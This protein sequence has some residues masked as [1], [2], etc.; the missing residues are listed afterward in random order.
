[1]LSGHGTISTIAASAHRIGS[2]VDGSSRYTPLAII[3]TVSSLNI[4]GMEQVVVRLAT[5]QRDAGHHVTVLALRGGPLEVELRER[6]VSVAVL[7]RGVISRVVGALKYFMSTRH[8]IVHA[9]NPTSLHYAALSKFVSRGGLVV[10]IHGD[11]ETHARLGTALEWKL[12]NSIVVVSHAAKRNLRLPC[13]DDK[14]TVIHNGIASTS[15]SDRRQPMRRALGAEN[16]LVGAIVA[17]IDGHKG[18]ATLLNSLRI[19]K[20][21]GIHLMMLVIGDGAERSNLEHFAATL[22]LDAQSVRFLGARRDVGDL[23]SAVDLFVLPSDTEG[24]PLSVLE[25]MAAGLPIIATRV[26]GLPELVDDGKEG[27]LVTPGDAQGLAEAIERMSQDPLLRA[28]LGQSAKT[29][30]GGE[31]S[32]SATVQNYDQVYRQVLDAKGA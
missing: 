15:D 13:G 18:H 7:K 4:G 31:F 28:T 29:R 20:D 21:R 5:A 11:Q 22:Q 12:A 8:H 14:V 30:A 24:L 9:H 19:L 6:G 16:R 3:H 10:T 1:M 2:G 26:G 32:L 17:R 25:A 27:I 23:L